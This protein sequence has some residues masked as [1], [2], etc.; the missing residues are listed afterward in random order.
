MKRKDFN[1][2][3]PVLLHCVTTD[4]WI[5]T[6]RLSSVVSFHSPILVATSVASGHCRNYS[7]KKNPKKHIHTWAQ[8]IL[9]IYLFFL[10][11][12]SRATISRSLVTSL[13]YV[14]MTMPLWLNSCFPCDNN[15]LRHRPKLSRGWSVAPNFGWDK[16]HEQRVSTECASAKLC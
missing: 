16:Q 2:L 6:H 3:N 14:I 15:L 4:L 1:I 8:F 10:P 13:N 5:M 11:K 12:T 7:L 9:F